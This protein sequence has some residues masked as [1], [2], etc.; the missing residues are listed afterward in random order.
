MAHDGL[1]SSKYGGLDNHHLSKE[2]ALPPYPSKYVETI[3]CVGLLSCLSSS[4]SLKAF[5]CAALLLSALH[6][7]VV[8]VVC[9]DESND[10]VECWLKLSEQLDIICEGGKL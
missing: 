5:C 2:R 7:C 8:D 10:R 6:A 3:L 4:F 9:T 1:H